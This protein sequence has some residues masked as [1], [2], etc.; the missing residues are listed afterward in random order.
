MAPCAEQGP[1]AYGHN[2]IG[3]VMSDVYSSPSDPVFFMHHT[4]VDRNWYR[5]QNADPNNRMYQLSGNVGLGNVL[6]SRGIRQDVR[7]A[8]MM[9]TRGGF[10]CYEYDY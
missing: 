10:L 3:S 7:V 1:H 5:W 4:F 9:D 6:T 2:G 8:D